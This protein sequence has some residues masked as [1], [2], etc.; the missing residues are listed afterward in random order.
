MAFGDAAR[1]CFPSRYAAAVV[2]V[3]ALCKSVCCLL[4]SERKRRATFYHYISGSRE[5]C[6]FTRN[7]YLKRGKGAQLTAPRK[8][9]LLQ[10]GAQVIER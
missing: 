5:G 4:R 9:K 10:H 2:L 3:T 7:L 8:C 1:I 6:I